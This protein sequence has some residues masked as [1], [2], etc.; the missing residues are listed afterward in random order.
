M[1]LFGYL[2]RLEDSPEGSFLFIHLETLCATT[3]MTRVSWFEDLYRG[4]RFP[5][6]AFGTPT[7]EKRCVNILDLHS[8]KASCANA[9]VREVIQ[10]IKA[11]EKDED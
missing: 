1:D 6:S 5:E 4:E 9:Y 2:A 11:I 8:C 3:L 7:C 10:I